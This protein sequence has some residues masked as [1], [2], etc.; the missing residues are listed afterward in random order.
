MTEND[1]KKAENARLQ[2]EMQ[3]AYRQTFST[4]AG[5]K[6]YED[7]K[8][9]CGFERDVVSASMPGIGIDPY[10]THVNAGKHRVFL[11]ILGMINEGKKK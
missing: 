9:F 2:K 7:M 6:V 3:I 1:A 4:K 5:Q 10:Q 11:R 8:N